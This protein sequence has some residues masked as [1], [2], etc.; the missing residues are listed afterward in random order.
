MPYSTSAKYFHSGMSGAP[1]ITGV[2]G[3]LISVLDACLVN[4]FGSQTVTVVVASAL[5]T[6]T[7]SNVNTNQFDEHTVVV[8]SG[9]TP[10]GLNGE[11][12]VLTKTSTGFTF[13]ATGIADGT[14]TGTITVKLAPAGWSKAFSGTNLAA[15]QSANPASTK[16]VLRVDDTATQNARVVSYDSMTDVNTGIG[17]CPTVTQM[18]GGLHWPK[19]NVAAGAS[20]PW[21]VV[22]D[23]R[24]V[25]IKVH[26]HGG[27]PS[28]EAG[29][30]YGAG[31][32][33]PDRSA[34]AFS[35][36]VLGAMVDVSTANT[37]GA[38]PLS[39]GLAHANIPSVGNEV[40]IWLQKSYSGI[41]S[42]VAGAKNAETYGRPTFG[43]TN[44]DSDSGYHQTATFTYPNPA[45][46]SLILSRY[47]VFQGDPRSNDSVSL[48][49]TM[50]GALFLPQLIGAST[51]N[52]LD[53]MDGQGPLT[54]RKLMMVKGN[55]PAA[56]TQDGRVVA[57]DITGPWS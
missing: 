28:Q 36:F 10:S 29:I 25:Y 2:A 15:Y 12:R 38:T 4:G 39:F 8:L 22:A 7:L 24:T 56:S 9:A 41:G 35:F 31:D 55:T 13:D 45:D 19:A 3:A 20:R 48:R 57:F 30:V 49:G 17:P 16:C 37:A 52:T 32:F 21:V 40:P 42:A 11:K 51:F 1:S 50:R 14:A 44:A 33:T 27:A 18:S 53:K 26:C 47:A 43:G 23:D 6:V 54:G 5:A 34:D 46:N